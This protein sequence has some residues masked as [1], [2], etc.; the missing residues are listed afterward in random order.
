[1]SGGSRLSSKIYPPREIPRARFSK[2]SF[3]EEGDLS[4]LLR[5]RTIAMYCQIS[6][7]KKDY[8]YER[9][10][11]YSSAIAIFA[12]GYVRSRRFL[13][14]YALYNYDMT[15]CRIKHPYLV[16]NIASAIS[17]QAKNM[18]ETDR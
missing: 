12:T 16:P 4:T 2:K 15:Y 6:L 13:D 5:T 3:V 14:R 9:S 11:T 17:H 1:M 8:D 18:E 10:A 7:R